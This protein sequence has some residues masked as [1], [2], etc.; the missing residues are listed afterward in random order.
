M[1][2]IL[3]QVLPMIR[4]SRLEMKEEAAFTKSLLAHIQASAPA[5]SEAVLTGSMA[6]RTF[7]REKRDVDVFVLFRRSVPRD[8][9]E[10]LIKGIMGKAFPGRAY[11]LSYAEHPYARFRLE[12][13][14]ID[15]VPAYRIADASERVSAVDRSVLHT[16]FVL[17]K[18]RDVDS[19]LLLK[20]FLQANSLYGAEIKIQGFSGYLCELL[21]IR[22]GSFMNL[23]RAAS[24]WKPPVF[25]DIKGYH[26]GK[27]IREAQLRLGRFV[28]IDPTDA[29]RNV[30]AAVS[31][32]NLSSFVR[33]CKS[34]LKKPSAQFFLR[35]PESFE[36]KVARAAKGAKLI[37]VTL[38]R[39]DVVDDVLW[40]QLHRMAGQL[41]LHLSGFG[42]KAI[43]ADDGQH[44]VRLALVLG[45]D[46][47]PPT[48]E[49][50]G[51]PLSMKPHVKRFRESHRGARFAIRKKKI[52]AI[53]KRPS[54]RAEA[55]VRE[56]FR[57]FSRTKSHL[58]CGEELVVVEKGKKQ[59][60]TSSK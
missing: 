46:L 8:R 33:L 47:L 31:P 16:S 20:S 25:I 1:Q 59:P 18:L 49:I 57:K 38:P 40:G 34:F 35:K 13:R 37:M 7:L 10:P 58:A 55:A 15:L 3:R 11:Q 42:P 41:E 32:E 51:P 6:K 56:F 52:F 21:V 24:K 43:L 60:K 39:P 27:A 12:G 17:K 54:G 45:T 26:K 5:G 14:R 48:M 9:L 22:Y 53:V 19:V 30:A 2:K 29:N 23:L 28:V 4:P 50:E 36:D 44:I